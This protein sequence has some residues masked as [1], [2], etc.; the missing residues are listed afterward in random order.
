MLIP[1]KIVS[2]T[3]EKIEVQM[4]IFEIFKKSHPKQ[5]A[6]MTLQSLRN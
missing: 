3:G 1:S 5:K 6:Y 4:N 2:F